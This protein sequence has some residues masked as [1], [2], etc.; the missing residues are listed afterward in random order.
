MI[1]FR[2]QFG[3][4]WLVNTEQPLLCAN[5]FPHELLLRPSGQILKTSGPM[6]SNQQGGVWSPGLHQA[7]VWS[8]RSQ[9]ID[10]ATYIC[11]AWPMT[12]DAKQTVCLICWQAVKYTD[13]HDLISI[14]KMIRNLNPWLEIE[15]VFRIQLVSP[16]S[17]E[18]EIFRC[19]QGDQVCSHNNLTASALLA[20]IHDL[21]TK[22]N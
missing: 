6:A 10:M 9:K 3:S 19:D 12:D 8:N 15:L 13:T 21:L 1:R 7:A 20:W 22:G 16:T 11:T 17:C 14:L 2:T 5:K 4:N 18:A